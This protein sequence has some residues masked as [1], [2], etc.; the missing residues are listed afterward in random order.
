[1]TV[2][3]MLAELRGAETAWPRV[4]LAEA[5]QL[6]EEGRG[7]GRDNAAARVYGPASGR[8]TLGDSVRGRAQAVAEGVTVELTVGEPGTPAA[9]YGRAQELGAVIRP[10]RAR[11]LTIP[12]DTAI[13]GGIRSLRDVAEPQFRPRRGGGWLVFG[14]AGLL[15][16][17]HPGPVTL[18]AK[19][20]LSDAFDDVVRVTPARLPLAALMGVAA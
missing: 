20:F 10:R 14:P 9:A 5:T 12:T 4:L 15:F 6:A 18:P 16:T 7:L 1:M 2:D 13:R 8:G 19:R 11:F 17:L 3:E